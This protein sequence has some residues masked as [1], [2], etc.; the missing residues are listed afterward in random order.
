MRPMSRAALLVP[1]AAITLGACVDHPAPSGP[2]FDLTGTG[3][4]TVIE[5]V[6]V[7]DGTST[8][9]RTT[10]VLRDG[11]IRAVGA[12]ARAPAG[13]TIVDG[14]GKTL[15]PGFIDAHTHSYGEALVDALVM[16]VT[17]ELEMFGD[18]E[19]AA[20]VRAEQ[21]A[22]RGDGW[23][24]VFTAGIMVT[25]PGGHGTQ[26]GWPIPTITTPDSAQAFVDARLAEGSDFIKIVHDD[27]STFGR[28]KPTVD[29]STLA[30]LVVAAHARGK[31]AVVHIGDL[32]DARRAVD[33][34]ADGLV[35]LFLDSL[36]DA[37]F[38]E[39]AARRNAFVVPTLT[40]LETAS[41]GSGG[42]AL[43]SDA[44]LAPY[45]SA[46][47]VA[48]LKLR[49]TLPVAP[50]LAGYAAAVATVRRLK[51]AGVPI[52]AGTDAPNPGTAHGAS[53]HR[54]LEL[55]VQAGLTPAEALRAATSAPAKAFR[56][57]DRGRVVVG[58][59]ADLVLVNGDPTADILATRDV[60]AVW[61]RG[62]RLD[63]EGYRA[64]I[65]AGQSVRWLGNARADAR[66]RAMAHA[67]HAH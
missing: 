2:D 42:S 11:T 57:V 19:F 40:V 36:P 23:A 63:R 48:N 37:A 4:V 53:M 32:A 30:A 56:L 6:R 26:Y 28:M 15:L 27:V 41:G 12:G 24:D 20:A 8:I 60:A 59:R 29:R 58:L 50:G 9:P 55:L 44:Q 43:A 10:V 61:K 16:G 3:P 14:R 31:L 39:L 22:G 52:L 47:N 17:T 65:A 33:V 64:A 34:G 38:A 51:A 45:I 5:N 49:F 7:F 13:A 1:V 46:D 21:A 62:V 66:A 35:H 54:E 67:T 18:P 25:A